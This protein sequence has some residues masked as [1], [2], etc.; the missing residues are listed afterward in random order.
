MQ[1]IFSTIQISNTKWSTYLYV[2]YRIFCIKFP[3][4]SQKYTSQVNFSFDGGIF[5]I[6]L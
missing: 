2:F 4:N 3:E 6:E 5:R 1:L